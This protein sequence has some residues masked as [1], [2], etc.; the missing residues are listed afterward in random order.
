MNTK[1]KNI[2]SDLFSFAQRQESGLLTLELGKHKERK[3]LKTLEVKQKDLERRLATPETTDSAK[4]TTVPVTT[5]DTTTAKSKKSTKSK[6]K[7]TTTEKKDGVTMLREEIVK[8]TS[9]LEVTRVSNLK[10]LFKTDVVT[11]N[12]VSTK[13]Q[14]Y[15]ELYTR[16]KTEVESKGEQLYN[17]FIT[18][19]NGLSSINKDMSV[20]KDVVSK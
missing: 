8:L 7:Q 13:V 6:N 20:S 2:L 11:H 19:K 4:K 5:E 18:K 9:E 14:E 12:V 10:L 3:L 16:N 15:N 17:N 1:F